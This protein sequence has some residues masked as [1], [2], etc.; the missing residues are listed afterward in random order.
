MSTA[1]IKF[2]DGL[3]EAVTIARA[4]VEDEARAS[5]ED[6]REAISTVASRCRVGRGE[7]LKLVHESRRP[8]DIGLRLWR[9]LLT[10][11]AAHLRLELARLGAEIDR[12]EALGG[13]DHSAV[14][15]LLNEAETLTSRLKVLV[16][17]A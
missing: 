5:G 3:S 11:Y 1:T 2:S 7:I 16:R 14:A 10:V 4:L 12:V 6:V 15:P 13:M 17:R 9:R 8:K